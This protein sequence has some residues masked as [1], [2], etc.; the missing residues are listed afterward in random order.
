MRNPGMKG[1]HFFLNDGKVYLEYAETVAS[2]NI[3]RPGNKSVGLNTFLINRQSDGPNFETFPKLFITGKRRF[4]L[5][6]SLIK[7][8]TVLYK[9][10]SNKNQVGKV[11][12][13]LDI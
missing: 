10:G 4:I 2:F 7:T 9:V 6:L 1:N 13:W 12:R 8:R 11:G 3:I 5:V